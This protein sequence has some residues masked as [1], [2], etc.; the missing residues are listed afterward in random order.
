MKIVYSERFLEH[1]TEQGHPENP[2]R[3]IAV[4]RYL[5]ENNLPYSFDKPKEISERELY[6]VHDE[7][8]IERLK[9]LS[10]MQQGAGDNPF[11]MNTFKIAKLAAGG[12]LKAAENSKKG[13]SFALIRPPGHHASRNAFGGF[14][15]LNNI[16]FAT[17][18]MLK[19][20]VKKAMIVDIDQHHGNGTQDIFYDDGRV[21]YLSFHQNPN[22]CFPWKSGFETENN[23]HIHNVVI[24]P[25]TK[26][27]GYLKI[28]EEKFRK[29]VNAFKP[30]LIG[31]SVGFDTFYKDYSCGNAIDIE[32]SATYNRIGGI[33]REEAEKLGARVFAVLE[34]GYYLGTLGQNFLSF[35]SAFL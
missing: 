4:I 21:F 35:C 32:D 19:S 9:F 10:D 11:S 23:E 16:A 18:S 27:A 13:F 22:T 15:Y 20:E 14:C 33:I 29:D 8:Y 1:E 17:A 7:E 12:A 28:F 5:K 31:V 6:M 26:D 30:E 2:Q 25:G 24:E 3:L 34:G